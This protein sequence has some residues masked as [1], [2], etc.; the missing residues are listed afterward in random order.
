M[1]QASGNRPLLQGPWIFS[2][3]DPHGV[4]EGR[5]DYT[6]PELAKR[7]HWIW[8]QKKHLHT[9]EGNIDQCIAWLENEET[10]RLRHVLKED[11]EDTVGESDEAAENKREKRKKRKKKKL[12]LKNG[13]NLKKAGEESGSEEVK[14]VWLDQERQYAWQWFEQDGDASGI[15]KQYLPCKYYFWPGYGCPD[16]FCEFSHN[17][18]IFLGAPF[19]D[20]LKSLHEHELAELAG[21]HKKRKTFVQPP[22]PEQRRRL[23]DCNPLQKFAQH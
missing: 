11:K 18:E 6:L 21:R 3:I 4:N 17:E 14:E 23:T 10:L 22:S 5:V 15:P 20:L 19:A 2:L 12:M 7:K 1:L 9:E 16:K 8:C 13:V